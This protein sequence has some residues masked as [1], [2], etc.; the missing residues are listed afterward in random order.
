VLLALESRACELGHETIHL[1]TTTLQLAA[2]ALY[3]QNGYAE[4]GRR[5]H[6]LFEL[7]LFD[8]RLTGK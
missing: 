4:I 6:G 3:E 8:K 1:D 7:I 5:Q 2:I